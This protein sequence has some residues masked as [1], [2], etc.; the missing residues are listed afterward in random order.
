MPTKLMQIRL[1]PTTGGIEMGATFYYCE[2][3]GDVDTN[4]VCQDVEI[5]HEPMGDRYVERTETRLSCAVCG[6]EVD[7][8]E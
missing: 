1:T 8:K 2:K 3:C 4:D 7:E 6:S 5:H